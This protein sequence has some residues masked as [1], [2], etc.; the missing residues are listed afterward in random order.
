LIRILPNQLPKDITLCAENEKYFTTM[1]V[2]LMVGFLT[3]DGWVQQAHFFIHQQ[4]STTMKRTATAVWQ[5]T[6]KEGKGTLTTQSNV[7]KETQYSYKSRFE[8]GTG[9]NPEELVAAA[10][11]GCFSMKLSFNIDA[12]G[13]KA[14][15]LETQ[16]EITLESGAL[17]NSHLIL[18]ANVPGI[19]QEKFDELVADAE[20]NC[21]IS[22]SLNTRITVAATLAS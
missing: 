13:F 14:E 2:N 18:N 10:H 20:K 15:R 6:G 17:T 7:L 12:A 16:C 3:F 22:K 21:P 11:A 8:E 9:T 19:S 5:G 1:G 4:Q